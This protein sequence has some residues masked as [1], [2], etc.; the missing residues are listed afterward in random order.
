[1]WDYIFPNKARRT[2]TCETESTNFPRR[3]SS[4]PYFLHILPHFSPQHRK[5]KKSSLTHSLHLH[6]PYLLA[7]TTHSQQSILFSSLPSCTIIEHEKTRCFYAKENSIE[8][9]KN[10]EDWK[11][12][13][14]GHISQIQEKHKSYTDN[15]SLFTLARQTIP[16]PTP[17][18]LKSQLSHTTTGIEMSAP[19]LDKR[20][21]KKKPHLSHFF[22]TNYCFIQFYIVICDR[23]AIQTLHYKQ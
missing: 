20:Q 9:R 14:G 6:L 11:S 7:T 19:L 10:E 23:F 5:Q 15:S 3:K 12:K 21:R 8:S 17:F 18:A 1:M 13:D 16:P 4:K 22:C 2:T